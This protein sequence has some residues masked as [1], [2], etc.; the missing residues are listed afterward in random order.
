M[1]KI[2]QQMQIENKRFSSKNPAL[3]IGI[4]SSKERKGI[5]VTMPK[6]PAPQ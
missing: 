2:G 5:I 1:G 4:D 3:G 6:T